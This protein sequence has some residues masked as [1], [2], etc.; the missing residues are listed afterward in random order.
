MMGL[1]NDSYPVVVSQARQV[2]DYFCRVHP[3]HDGRHIT[4]QVSFVQAV[5]GKRHLWNVSGL[6]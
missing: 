4:P 1:S 3:G 2:G 5:T 6:K